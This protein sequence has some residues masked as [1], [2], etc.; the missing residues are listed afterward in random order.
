[1]RKIFI[2][3]AILLPFISCNKVKKTENNTQELLTQ[4]ENKKMGT[5]HLTTAEFKAKIFDFTANNEWKYEGDKPCL[6]D[7]YADWCGPCR[8]VAPI[9]EDLAAEY[10]DKIYIYKVDTDAEQEVA[11]AFGIQSIPSLLFVP[12]NGEPQM[13][14]GAL[15]KADLKRA[16]EEVLFNN[17]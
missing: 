10:G 8:M 7:F 13:M 11:A 15:P 12:M 4:K 3:L 5:L 14:M 17:K 2:F 6:V 9:L 1:M 16:I